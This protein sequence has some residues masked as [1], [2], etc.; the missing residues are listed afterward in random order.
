MK[1]SLL[2]T[3]G[4]AAVV[5][6][7]A[8]C[9]AMQG[10]TQLETHSM[11]IREISAVTYSGTI[12][13]EEDHPTLIID[14]L[15]RPKPIGPGRGAGGY[16]FL[17]NHL[18]DWETNEKIGWL[19]GMCFTLD[20]GPDGPWTGEVVIGAGGPFHSNCNF[21]YLLDGGQI[22][23][24][25]DIDLNAMELDKPL[26]VA[27]IGG[28]GKYEGARG[29]V[30]IVQDPPGQPITYKVEMHYTVPVQEEK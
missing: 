18:H 3:L 16:V 6:V 7:T 4:T 15:K 21:N 5:S 29:Q 20:H 14:D 17:N 13:D 30:T 23:A 19:R 11:T 28:T 1:F 8:G 2:T 25:G 9:T 24:Q 12:N 22:A 26:S 10:G 27:I